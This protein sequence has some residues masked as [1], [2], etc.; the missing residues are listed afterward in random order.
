MN[1]GHFC[2]GSFYIFYKSDLFQILYKSQWLTIQKMS[3]IFFHFNLLVV[4]GLLD[5]INLLA[6]LIQTGLQT[7]S[8]HCVVAKVKIC[9]SPSFLQLKPLKVLISQT[10]LKKTDVTG[11]N[12][13]VKVLIFTCDRQ[14]MMS[15]T[16]S[17]LP[18]VLRIFLLRYLVP[19]QP[20]DICS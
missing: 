2:N 12:C 20:L 6:E 5:D 19:V 11:F 9:L 8:A 7:I 10:S 17:D 14:M 4:L 1:S 13:L 3:H 15:S 18:Q 16:S